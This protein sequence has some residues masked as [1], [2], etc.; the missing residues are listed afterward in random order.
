MKTLRSAALWLV[1]LVP[2]FSQIALA[3]PVTALSF[4]GGT[5]RNFSETGTAGWS[6][7]TAASMLVTSLGYYDVSGTGL[8][9]SHE[10]GIFDDTSGLLLLSATVA[11]GNTDPL[12]GG[13]RFN[14]TLIGSTLLPAGDYFIGAFVTPGADPAL[15][16]AT[17][18]NLEP[19]ITFGGSRDNS[20]FAFGY[21]GPPSDAENS[22]FGPN[23]QFDAP[24]SGTPELAAPQSIIPLLFVSCL[25]LMGRRSVSSD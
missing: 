23:F 16:M 25:L 6:F 8:T 19:G 9:N 12:S 14:S 17:T 1:L 21:V 10:V 3:V 22:F 7:T 2:S 13:F 5:T 24:A 20:T 4:T 11:A 18:V 15:E